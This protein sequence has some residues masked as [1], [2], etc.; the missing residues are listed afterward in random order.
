[1]D[2]YKLFYLANFLMLVPGGFVFLAFVPMPVHEWIRY[3]IVLVIGFLMV[4]FNTRNLKRGLE[5]QR[6]EEVYGR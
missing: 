2:P 3:L 4:V 5:H 1:M 6:K